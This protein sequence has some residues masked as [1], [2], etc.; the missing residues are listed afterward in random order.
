LPQSAFLKL[1]IKHPESLAKQ[2]TSGQKGAKH[3]YDKNTIHLP[4][5][6]LPLANGRIY[7]KGHGKK[8]QA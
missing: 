4:R 1:T 8:A 3:N 7:I 2:G 6:H 5:Q